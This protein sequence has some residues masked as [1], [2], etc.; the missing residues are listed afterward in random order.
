MKR[1]KFL[2]D[3]HGAW[4]V[5]FQALTIGGDI[6]QVGD[7]GV[8]FD[9]MSSAEQLDS[10]INS[11][12]SGEDGSF[13]FIRGNH[14]NPQECLLSEHFI[15][16]GTVT[17]DGVMYLG[18]AA[19][20]DFMLRTENVDWWRD[21]ELSDERLGECIAKWEETKPDV[22]VSHDTSERAASM[23]MMPLVGSKLVFPSRTRDAIDEMYRIH[24]PKMHIYGHWHHPVDV[25]FEGTRLVCLGINQMRELEL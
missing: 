22:L 4:Y 11:G 6:V 21:E 9:E 14:D 17:D 18:G 12:L 25:D 1:T 3:I 2:G 8:G 5:L 20:I 23:L 15:E 19:S 13:S 10:L 24:R 16:D 7:I